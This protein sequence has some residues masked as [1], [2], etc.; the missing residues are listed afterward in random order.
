MVGEVQVSDA[1]ETDLWRRYTQGEEPANDARSS[2]GLKPSAAMTRS[3]VGIGRSAKR[4]GDMPQVMRRGT[5]PS[6]S[7]SQ[8]STGNWRTTADARRSGQHGGQG[9]PSG[10]GDGAPAHEKTQGRT[11][12]QHRGSTRP[13]D[14]G[15]KDCQGPGVPGQ[16]RGQTLSGSVRPIPQQTSR[17]GHDGHRLLLCAPT[18]QARDE[19][20]SSGLLR[21]PR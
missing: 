8:D 1:G 11:P 17:Q 21:A 18:G 3:G 6:A 7:G 12:C 14:P 2:S 4:S 9:E 20:R 5:L 13:A 19:D 10:R 15:I 16:V